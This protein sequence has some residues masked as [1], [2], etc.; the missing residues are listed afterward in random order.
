[1]A[2]GQPT[3]DNRDNAGNADGISFTRAPFLVTPVADFDDPWAMAFI[4]DS[5]FALVTEQSGRLMLWESGGSVRDVAGAPAV[6]YA[7]QGGLGDVVLA[8][9]FAVSRSIYLSWTEQGRG[10]QDRTSGAVVGRARLSDDMTRLE[11]LEVIWRQSPFVR[12]SGH[13]G[14]RIAFGP[15]AMLYISSGDRQKFVPAQDMTGN[16]GKIIRLHPD[17][18]VPSDNPF[19][20]D[21][22]IGGQIWSLGHRNPLGLAFDGRGRLWEIE[23]GPAGGDE[24]NLVERGGNYGW[25]S[26]SNGV[27]YDGNDI[28][29]QR[30]GDG[31]VA[32]VLWW[33]PAISPASLM[34][35]SGDQFPSWR[36]NAFVA[37]LGG[38][39]LIRVG[40][41]GGATR[42]L[43]RWDMG[44]RVRSVV[45]GSDGAIWLLGDG[46]SRGNGRLYRLTP[47][48]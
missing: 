11:N 30:A 36:G 18:S 4:P 28:P 47:R 7:G 32:P 24:L 26:V 14:H 27:H 46:G 22:G 25:P 10:S 17:G 1:M 38:A 13:F 35:Y 48:P 39:A 45:Q 37:A 23:M 16:L 3:A 40:L 6:S 9:D 29:D 31:F 34:I 42:Q 20:A 41:D 33:N 5:P 43:D 44:F 21:V 8:P 12:G 15:D 19:A 2:A